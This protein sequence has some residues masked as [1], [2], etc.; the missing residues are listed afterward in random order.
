MLILGFVKKQAR[1]GVRVTYNETSF[2]T[3]GVGPLAFSKNAGL[4]HFRIDYTL[5]VASSV[6]ILYI[7]W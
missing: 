2:A 3:S 7:Q 5:R 1:V 4:R 6:H